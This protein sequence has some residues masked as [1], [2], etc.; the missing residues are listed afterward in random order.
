MI[1]ASRAV[2]AG[3]RESATI[4]GEDPERVRRERDLYRR[5][6]D[7]GSQNEIE[8]FVAEALAL[9][10]EVA[11]AHQGYLELVGDGDPGGEPRWSASH[12]LSPDQVEVVRSA[13]SQG[14]I[15]AALQSGKTI[16]T[17]SALL[18]PR[19]QELESVRV[20]RIEAVLC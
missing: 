20:G 12:A 14:I 6:L 17:Q 4:D 15:A 2:G 3:R 1:V 5:L 13:V 10:T 18:D 19:F 9:V 7:L 11:G 8:P 16:V